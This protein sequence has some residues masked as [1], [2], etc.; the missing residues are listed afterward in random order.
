ALSSE[1][2]TAILFAGSSTRL[3]GFDGWSTG[4]GFQRMAVDATGV[5]VL[6]V[7]RQL[8][9]GFFVE[10]AADGGRIYST[11]GGVGDPAAAS[12]LGSFRDAAVSYP[13][14]MAV[15]STAG[16]VFFLSGDGATL[17]LLAFDLRSYRLVGS[18]E[19]SGISGRAG[20]LTRWGPDGLA[21]R[22]DG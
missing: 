7:T 8:F 18:M 21:F 19:L 2:T 22:T 1:P 15:D 3:Y 16:R 11:S 13:A 14:P 17:T 10:M 6:D 9:A 4:W 5:S 12:L 20:N